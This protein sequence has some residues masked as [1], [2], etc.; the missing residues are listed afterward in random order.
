MIPKKASGH[1]PTSVA[2]LMKIAVHPMKSTL[3]AVALLLAAQLAAIPTLA[4]GQAEN[5]RCEYREN[6]LGL[7]ELTPRLSWQMKAD[8]RGQRQV[9]ERLM[10]LEDEAEQLAPAP[11]GGEAVRAESLPAALRLGGGET[12]RQFHFEI[13]RH[14]P[15]G[16]LVPIYRTG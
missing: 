4:A 13:L 5:L 12:R 11:A 3:T 15:S 6:P 2:C 10:K 14:L 7:D 9:N 1:A 16:E 8:E